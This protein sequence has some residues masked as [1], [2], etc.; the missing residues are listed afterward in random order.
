[1]MPYMFYADELRAAMFREQYKSSAL[2]L[3]VTN[4]S[5]F[6]FKSRNTGTENRIDVDDGKRLE[7]STRLELDSDSINLT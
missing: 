6:R 4:Q 7:L 1:M 5:P 3:P 2:W